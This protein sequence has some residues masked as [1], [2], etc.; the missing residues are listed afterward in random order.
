MNPVTAVA[1]KFRERRQARPHTCDPLA[2]YMYSEREPGFQIGRQRIGKAEL[3][4]S[5][6][7]WLERTEGR[8]A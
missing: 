5:L 4:N 1:R 7:E 8:R 2:M 3:Q 6:Q